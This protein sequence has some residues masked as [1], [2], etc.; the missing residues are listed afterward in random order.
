VKLLL[1]RVFEKYYNNRSRNDGS[2]IQGCT[3]AVESLLCCE[4]WILE[5]KPAGE[6]NDA[7]NHDDGVFMKTQ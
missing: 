4:K 7:T 6:G 3:D 1:Q 2:S 5:N